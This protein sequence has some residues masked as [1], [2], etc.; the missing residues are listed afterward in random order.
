MDTLFSHDSL[1][2]E[3]SYIWPRAGDDEPSYDGASTIVLQ[4]F[5]D[6]KIHPRGGIYFAVKPQYALAR[7]FFKLNI[8]SELEEYNMYKVDTYREFIS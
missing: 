3:Q 5:S 7:I 2:S 6:I 1:F 4:G 8:Y